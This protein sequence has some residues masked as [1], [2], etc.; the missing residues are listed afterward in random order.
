MKERC[1]IF[2]TFLSDVHTAIASILYYI[3]NIM[4]NS[5]SLHRVDEMKIDG[6]GLMVGETDG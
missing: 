5:L 4:F 1:V 6:G 2:V 3:C